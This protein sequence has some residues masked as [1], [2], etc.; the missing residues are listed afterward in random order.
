MV[1]PKLFQY[2]VLWHPTEK[3]IK[4]DGLKSKV[5]ID[6][7]TILSSDQQNVLMSAA[8]E[9]PTDKKNELD[10]IEIVVRPF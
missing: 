10:Q 4:E 6:M 1:T 2:A 8:M 5:L 7:K 3:Q 9:I